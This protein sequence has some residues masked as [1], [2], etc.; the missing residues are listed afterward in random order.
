M[1]AQI[2]PLPSRSWPRAVFSAVRLTAWTLCLG[3]CGRTPPP[4]PPRAP[5]QLQTVQTR[6][7]PVTSEYVSTL[8]SRR[9]VTI[10]PQV[11]GRVVRIAV[12]SGM[13]VRPGQLLMEIDPR[14]QRATVRSAQANQAALE[15]QLVYAQ[16]QYE[17]MEKLFQRGLVARADLDQA[18]QALDATA[19]QVRSSG[20]QARAQTVELG[21]FRVNAPVAGIVG[22]VPAHDGDYVTPQTTLTTLNVN[23]ALEAYIQVPA[24]RAPELRTGLPVEILVGAAGR[25][26]IAARLA[27][28]LPQVAEGLRGEVAETAPLDFVSPQV[29]TTTQTL[30]VKCT[31]ANA[32]GRLRAG[33]YVRARIVWRTGKAP[34]VPVMSVVRQGG[35]AFVFVAEPGRGGLV[36]RQRPI[37]LGPLEGQEYVVASGL[38]PG[39]R[40]VVS[41]IQ[42]LAD[43]MP[44][45]AQRAPATV[46]GGAPI[47]AAPP[48]SPMG[49]RPPT[50]ARIAR[51]PCS[52]TFSSAGRCSRAWSRS[53]SRCSAPSPSRVCPSPSIRRWRRPR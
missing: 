49:G 28:G 12:R 45:E 6:D 44:I 7:V 1:R 13:K 32:G 10:L 25:A 14:L 36:V 53:S 50:P 4:P 46:D 20:E 30:L 16:R 47:P 40:I 27:Q 43:G 22:D 18:R 19:A 15:A 39:E 5:V 52:S 3:A 31:L 26:D 2:H 38:K 21:Y 48:R 51:P 29:D 23:L 41:G 11:A 17:R 24:D 8:V 42:K 33:E 35:Q 37:S 9:Q 34:L